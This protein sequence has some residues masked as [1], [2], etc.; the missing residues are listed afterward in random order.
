M[1]E[2]GNRIYDVDNL[3]VQAAKARYVAEREKVEKPRYVLEKDG[4]LSLC[5]LPTNIRIFHKPLVGYCL[6]LTRTSISEK[7]NLGG[8]KEVILEP[9]KA[10]QQE[11]SFVLAQRLASHKKPNRTP[12]KT[13]TIA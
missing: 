11:F 12:Q 13:R 1:Y 3:D 8:F 10:V 9:K 4:T 6:D 7:Q 5:S 2:E